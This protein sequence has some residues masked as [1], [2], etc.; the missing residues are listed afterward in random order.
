[1]NKYRVE[2]SSNNSGGNWWLKDGDWYALERAGWNV[3]WSKELDDTFLFSKEVKKTGRWLGALARKATIELE[4][5]S[6]TLALATAITW[7][8]DTLPYQDAGAEGCSCCGEPHGFYA[9]RVCPNCGNT[10]YDCREI[11]CNEL[12]GID[13]E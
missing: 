9:S 7:W 2:Y 12:E 11:G 10:L 6:K 13:K 4:A 8:S 5:Y 1:M 3:K